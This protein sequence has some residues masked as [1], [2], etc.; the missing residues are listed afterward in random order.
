MDSQGQLEVDLSSLGG[1]AIAIPCYDGKI[2]I[3]QAADLYHAALKFKQLGIKNCLLYEKGNALIDYSRNK[4]VKKFMEDTDCQKLIFLDA[5]IHF[6]WEDLVRL[7]AFSSKY[8]VVCG[9][10]P[11]KQ[12]IPKFFIN[13]CYQEGKV[14]TNELGLVSIKGAGAGFLI[15]DRSVFETMKPKCQNFF[16][17][18]KEYIEYFSCGVKD[19][20]LHGEDITFMRKW[21]EDCAG[22]VWLDPGINLVHVGMKSYDSQFQQYYME[23]IEQAELQEKARSNS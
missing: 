13:P 17:E 1:V 20:Q 21:V 18:D 14:I 16:V 6:K 7:L 22:E 11:V 9:T 2:I 19:K 15:I 12:D 23:F 3:E 10:Y 8:P 4:L 5:D